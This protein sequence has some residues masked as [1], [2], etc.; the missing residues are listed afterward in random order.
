[1]A[2]DDSTLTR[3]EMNEF[4]RRLGAQKRDLLG[5]MAELRRE[6]AVADDDQETPDDGSGLEGREEA[7][8]QISFIR[9]ELDR[10]ERAMGRIAEGTY[11]LSEISGRPIP[12]W[13]AGG[14]SHR[15]DAR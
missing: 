15:H 8:G 2:E 13:S 12:S 9:D 3:V 7:L 11:G 4:K 6:V 5:Q 1:M 14:S 10:V